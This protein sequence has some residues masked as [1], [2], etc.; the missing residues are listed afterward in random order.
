MFAKIVICMRL[1]YRTTACKDRLSANICLLSQTAWKDIID[2]GW[3]KLTDRKYIYISTGGWLSYSAYKES[4]LQSTLIMTEAC[5][6][7]CMIQMEI[8]IFFGTTNHKRKIHIFHSNFDI[9]HPKPNYIMMQYTKCDPSIFT[10]QCF[11]CFHNT[12]QLYHSSIH[13]YTQH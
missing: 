4:L 2:K 7:L 8:S 1:S 10:I 11:K 5:N 13:T 6:L 9:Y 12:T 3:L